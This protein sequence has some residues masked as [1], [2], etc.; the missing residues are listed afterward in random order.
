M[1]QSAGRPAARPL[2][3]VKF[4]DGLGQ[5]IAGSFLHGLAC[6]DTPIP[7]E[8]TPELICEVEAL[9]IPRICSMRSSLSTGC[10]AS[11]WSP[12]AWARCRVDMM[13]VLEAGTLLRERPLSNCSEDMMGQVLFCLVRVITAAV[14]ASQR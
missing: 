14:G 11:P 3:T 13:H 10:W 9:R 7:L 6:L 2:L 8:D 12:L 4:K 5:A 1:G